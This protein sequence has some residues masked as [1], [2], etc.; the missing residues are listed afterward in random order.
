M[1]VGG[2]AV[3]IHGEPRLTGDISLTGSKSSTKTLKTA[4]NDGGLVD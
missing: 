4:G 2:Q 1:V 3:L